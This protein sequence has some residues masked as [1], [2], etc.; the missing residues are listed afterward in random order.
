ML[1]DGRRRPRGEVRA[2]HL[3]E[4]LLVTQEVLPVRKRLV[5]GHGNF[6]IVAAADP[7][8]GAELDQPLEVPSLLV[9]RHLVPWLSLID[10]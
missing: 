2:Q 10:H 1:E 4:D 5:D 7:I 3:G 9:L 8:E 6:A